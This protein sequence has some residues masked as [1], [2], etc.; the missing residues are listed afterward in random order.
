MSFE[1]VPYAASAPPPPKFSVS[2]AA[3]DVRANAGSQGL[4]VMGEAG[5]TQRLF[6]VFND[7]DAKLPVVRVQGGKISQGQTVRLGP[8]A[9]WG[10]RWV[11]SPPAPSMRMA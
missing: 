7:P 9:A 3:V 2:K 6:A 11:G 4:R 1:P 5:N 10:G 8:A